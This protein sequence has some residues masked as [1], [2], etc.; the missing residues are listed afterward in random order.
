MKHVS[1]LRSSA[2]VVNPASLFTLIELLVVIAIIAILASMLLPALNKARESAKGSKCSSQLKQIGTAG[3][4]YSNDYD[5]MLMMQNYKIAGTNYP[6]YVQLPKMNYLTLG[7]SGR[8]T[9][10]CCPS[11]TQPYEDTT[12]SSYCSYA[13]NSWTAPDRQF[14]VKANGYTFQIGKRTQIPRPSEQMN[15]VDSYDIRVNT[16]QPYTE[17]YRASAINIDI[18]IHNRYASNLFLDGHTAK[19][20]IFRYPHDGIDRMP[21]YWLGGR[22]L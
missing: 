22:Q 8:S 6:W 9:L 11:Q 20:A 4:L 16:A 17:G 12:F 5:D 2:H 1:P 18:G 19:E 13:I 14:K 21:G 3:A 10:F 7:G 15:F